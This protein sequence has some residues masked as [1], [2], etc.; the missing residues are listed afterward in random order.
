MV[1]GHDGSVL[2]KVS[3]WCYEPL[4]AGKEAVDARIAAKR[5]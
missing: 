5:Q 4:D 1:V 3:G 2:E